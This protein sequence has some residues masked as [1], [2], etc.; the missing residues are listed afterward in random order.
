[1]S[2]WTMRLPKSSDALRMV[3]LGRRCTKSVTAVARERVPRRDRGAFDCACLTTTDDVAPGIGLMAFPVG[4][5]L[6]VATRV[7]QMWH[8]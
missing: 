8:E 2:S 4:T 7:M 1:M 6:H 3:L 5:H